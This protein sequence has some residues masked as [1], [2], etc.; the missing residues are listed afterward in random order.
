MNWPASIKAHSSPRSLIIKLKD[1]A[2]VGRVRPTLAA[3]K[4]G[5]HFLQQKNAASS[6]V[7][8]RVSGGAGWLRQSAATKFASQLGVS[9]MENGEK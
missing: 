3:A 4:N 2:T 8:G 7:A 6:A 5:A 1:W 9:R